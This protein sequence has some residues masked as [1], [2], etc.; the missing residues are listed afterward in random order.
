MSQGFFTIARTCP[1]CHGEGT[2]V[3]DPCP[4]CSGEG[5][6]A[7]ERTI[8]VTVPAGVD[9]GT[10]L[11]LAGEGEHGRRDGPPGDLYVDLVVQPHPEFV[12]EGPHVLSDVEIT[13]AQAVL[14][15]STDV[16][17]LHGKE[18]LE[19]PSG[20]QH[21]EAFR[22]RGKGVARL[23]GR[24]RGDHIVRVSILVPKPGSLSEEQLDLLRKLAESEGSDVRVDK[25]VLDRVRDLFG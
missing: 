5:R 25:K 20:T 7:R 17:T 2:I 9:R 11:R 23:G 21:G 19:I 6:V 1:Q 8:E 3:T 18:T 15:T 16:T 4:D 22:L 12:R 10:R 13:F 24:S 14:G